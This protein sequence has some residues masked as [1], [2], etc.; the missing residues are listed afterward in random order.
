MGKQRQKQNQYNNINVKCTEFTNEL[1]FVEHE[2]MEL[3]KNKF[4]VDPK[5]DDTHKHVSEDEQIE[6]YANNYM[7]G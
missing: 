3:Y 1:F 2:I 7:F 6:R 4:N 5:S